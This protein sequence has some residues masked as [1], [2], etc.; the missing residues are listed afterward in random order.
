[1]WAGWP[2]GR[3]P[4]QKSASVCYILGQREL[5]NPQGRQ[6]AWDLV[7]SMAKAEIQNPNWGKC[8]LINNV[9]GLFSPS[10]SLSCATTLIAKLTLRIILSI[11]H[12][13]NLCRITSAV[14]QESKLRAHA[15]SLRLCRHLL[16]KFITPKPLLQLSLNCACKLEREFQYF[17]PKC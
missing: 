10:Q 5:G 12:S 15:D 14:T 6:F 2:A 13:K 4:H 7:S 1:M 17:G 9:P 16:D 11:S 8:L 3:A